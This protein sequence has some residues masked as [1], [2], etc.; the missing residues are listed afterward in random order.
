MAFD[1]FISYPHNDKTTADAACAALEAAGIRCWIAPRDVAPGA[2]WAAAIVDAIS[3]CRAVVLIFSSHANRSTQI[4][5]EVQRAFENGVPVVP[6]RIEDVNPQSALAYYMTSVH[7]LDALTPPLEDHLKSLVSSLRAILAAANPIEE[8]TSAPAEGV[9]AVPAH[10]GVGAAR[11]GSAPVSAESLTA[12]PLARDE[13]HS[14]APVSIPRQDRPARRRPK[15]RPRGG[16]SHE[17]T[18][19]GKLVELFVIGLIVGVVSFGLSYLWTAYKYKASDFI[20]YASVNAPDFLLRLSTQFHALSFLKSFVPANY[21]AHCALPDPRDH[22]H[23]VPLVLIDIGEDS[24]ADWA[25]DYNNI[26]AALPRVPHDRLSEVFHRLVGSKPLLVVVDIDL[27]PE[28]T[29]AKSGPN[30]NPFEPDVRT[31]NKYEK[32]IRDDVS[33]MAGATIFLVA[34]P[35]I[36]QPRENDPDHYYTYA[37]LGTILYKPDKPNVLFGQAEQILDDDAVERRFPPFLPVEYSSP[38]LNPNSS[39]PGK[40][41]HLAVRVCQIQAL[42]DMGWCGQAPQSQPVARTAKAE[43]VAEPN[44][45]GVVAHAEDDP[46]QFRY[47]LPIEAS[48]LA[49]LGVKKIE[50]R[51]DFDPSV[52]DGAVVVLG[53]TA[54]GRGDYH[55]TPLDVLGGQTPGMMV[56]ANEL[57]GSLEGKRLQAPGFWSAALEKLLLIVVSTGTVFVGFWRIMIKR[58]AQKSRGP[59]GKV[60]YYLTVCIHFIAVVGLVLV[61]NTLIVVVISFDSL[62]AGRLVDPIT[63]V[64]AVILDAVMDLCAI[65]SSGISGWVERLPNP[66]GAL[67]ARAFPRLRS[68]D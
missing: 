18:P 32:A 22:T 39:D 5:R 11:P 54:W 3:S 21:Q 35:L 57:I 62:V 8:E 31:F 43:P 46:I 15:I 33:A 28:G 36:R 23:C 56:V 67:V 34:Q 24:C 27:H 40:F 41:P 37:P 55:F 58:P 10:E 59:I 50:A 44:F 68:S 47:S 38:A 13:A 51:S 61:I 25:K 45:G 63:P 12:L 4:Q 66:L 48:E 64:I 7:W 9:A 29:M 52:L 42:R 60:L 16:S 53:S 1:V 2:I 6:F 19:L 17:T 30:T 49:R 14:P 26:C 65:M 20:Q